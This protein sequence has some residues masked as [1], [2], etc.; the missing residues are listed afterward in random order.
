MYIGGLV[1]DWKLFQQIPSWSSAISVQSL[2]VARIIA[3][4]KSLSCDY[5]INIINADTYCLGKLRKEEMTLQESVKLEKTVVC[6]QFQTNELTNFIMTK[7]FY[8]YF[9]LH[10]I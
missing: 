3:Q 1:P 5:F 9:F 2:A 10:T 4:L 6:R 8:F 7:P